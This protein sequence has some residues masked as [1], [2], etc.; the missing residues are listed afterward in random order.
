MPSLQM[1]VGLATL[2][3][4]YKVITLIMLLFSGTTA[5]V[6]LS[7]SV[8][9]PTSVNTTINNTVTSINAGYALINAGDTVILGL[10]GLVVIITLFWP[11]IDGYIKTKKKSK[12]SGG[13]M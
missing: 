2:F 6:A 9:V 11:L 3:G 7:G 10:I 1:L 13:F 8:D 12:S 4:V 5:Q